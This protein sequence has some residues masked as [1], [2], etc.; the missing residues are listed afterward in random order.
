[1][2]TEIKFVTSETHEKN[3][4]GETCYQAQLRHNAVLN[5]KETKQ[6][7]AA[8]SGKRLSDVTYYVDSLS[9]FIAQAV[10]DGHRLDFGG[11][12]VGLNPTFHVRNQNPSGCWGFAHRSSLHS[13]FRRVGSFA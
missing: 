9:E 6:A 11:F 1:M 5:E 7:F 8:H 2:S 3:A 13:R 12:S 10:T 4:K